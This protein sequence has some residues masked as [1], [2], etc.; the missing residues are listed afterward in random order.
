[1]QVLQQP[2]NCFARGHH[3]SE[4]QLQHHVGFQIDGA[5]SAQR[6]RNCGGVCIRLWFAALDVQFSLDSQIRCTD[7]QLSVIPNVNVSQS[8]DLLPEVSTPDLRMHAWAA[9]RVQPGHGRQS[10]HHMPH[11]LRRIGF[12]QDRVMQVFVPAFQTIVVRRHPTTV[13]DV[14]H[15]SW[16]SAAGFIEIGFHAVGHGDFAHVGPLLQH[17]LNG[18]GH[19]A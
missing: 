11:V 9:R 3:V 8:P 17:E 4:L 14:C 15:T 19:S 13:H 10:S 2:P 18:S 5:C 7:L 16:S 12:G 1:M 6:G